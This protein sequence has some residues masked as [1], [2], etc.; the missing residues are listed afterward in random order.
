M[1]DSTRSPPQKDWLTTIH[2]PPKA[3]YL[4]PDERKVNQHIKSDVCAN[5]FFTHIEEQ[6]VPEILG[7]RFG[8]LNNDKGY[9]TCLRKQQTLTVPILTLMLIFIIGSDTHLTFGHNFSSNESAI[10]LALVDT[11]KTEAQLV[12]ENLA[13]NNISLASQ[14]ADRALALLTDNVTKEIAERNRRLANDLKT[15]LITL[16]TESTSGNGTTDD[17]NFLVTDI[18]GI[19]DEIVTSRIDPEQLN[20]S[21][22]QAS[23]M[24]EL[25]DKV[26]S[27]YGDAYAAGFDMT[28]MSMMMSGG[29]SDGGMQS[30]MSSMDMGTD[31]MSMSNMS[32]SEATLINVTNYQTAKVL[33]MKAQELF[34]SQLINASLAKG[35]GTENQ[36]IDNI[37]AALKELVTSID[38]KASPMEIMTIVHT[39]LHPNLLTA[40][41]L[42]LV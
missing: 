22:I 24:V 25:I 10:F 7:S 1:Q 30:M 31:N 40:Y 23:R 18:D 21:T 35:S 19:L 38:N 32:I 36:S 29:G 2:L 5:R 26:L 13:R 3:P 6:K 17:M 8:T 39:K 33:A 15:D 9:N 11:M 12:Q 42:K 16:K 14:H 34:D 20:N 37:A 41:G 27:N 28:N 4:N